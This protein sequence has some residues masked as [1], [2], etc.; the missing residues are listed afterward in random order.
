MTNVPLILNVNVVIVVDPGEID[1][2][3]TPTRQIISNSILL[4]DKL[5]SSETIT[6]LYPFLQEGWPL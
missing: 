2:K 3:G 5:A 1:F 4:A 6:G